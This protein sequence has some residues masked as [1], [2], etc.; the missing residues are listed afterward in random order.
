MIGNLQHT[1]SATSQTLVEELKGVS[2]IKEPG[3]DVNYF[4][5]CV[6]EL[7]CRISGVGAEPEDQSVI[8]ATTFLEC[9]V[10]A[11]KLKALDLLGNID[12][13]TTALT[14]TSIVIYLQAT[15]MSFKGQ[16][17][18]TPQVTGKIKQDE[19]LSTIHVAIK[20]ISTKIG[21]NGDG[22]N[23]GGRPQNNQGAE[24]RK[25]YN[26]GKNGHLARDCQ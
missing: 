19:E 11:F 14:W 6:V 5:Y 18:W 22:A 8:A 13:N 10:L 1:K 7:C 2:L 16:H 23:G 12:D 26:C 20:K 4:G 25:C 24:S 21:S 3:Q 9:D 17:L 15:Y